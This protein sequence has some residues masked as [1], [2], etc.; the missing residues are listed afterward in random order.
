MYTHLIELQ[1]TLFVSCSDTHAELRVSS[2][3][4]TTIDMFEHA[5]GAFQKNSF[6]LAHEYMFVQVCNAS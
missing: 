2:E 6:V 5:L 1:L 3:P 4:Y